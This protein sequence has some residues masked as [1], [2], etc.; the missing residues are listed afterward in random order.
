MLPDFA[1]LNWHE[2]GS[3]ELARGPARQGARRRDRAVPPRGGGVVG[4]VEHGPALHAGDDRASGARGR[5][6]RRRHARAESRAAGSPAPVLLHGLDESCWPL[7]EH[8]GVCGV[9]TRIGMEDTLKLPDGSVT[10]G[11]RRAG[12][13]GGAAAQSVGAASAK[14]AK[15][16]PGTTT[17]L[18]SA[19]SSS[20]G[21]GPLP[22]SR[23]HH[24]LRLLAR[25]DVAAE[26][27][28]LWRRPVRPRPRAAAG[29]RGD[30]ATVRRC[31]RCATPTAGPASAG[32]G[33]RCPRCGGRCSPA[34][35][36]TAQR[37]GRCATSPGTSR[38]RDAAPGRVCWPSP[39]S[40]LIASALDRSS[41]PH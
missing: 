35:V 27:D 12:V 10:P 6:R 37:S 40:S 14:S 16:K 24:E 19:G 18:T 9:Q 2:P 32:T 41:V 11:Q 3:P 28:A 30:A 1:S 21:R 29:C 23:W 20:R 22:V 5:R 26:Q 38:P 39:G 4:G 7:L 34:A 13:G 33:W 36:R 25:G 8:A 17:Q 31:A 15:S